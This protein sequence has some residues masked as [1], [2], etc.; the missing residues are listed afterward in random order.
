M[1]EV[2]AEARALAA[3]AAVARVVGMALVK[4]ATGVGAVAEAARERVR[5]EVA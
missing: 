3:P 5:L 1:G 4:R 2:M